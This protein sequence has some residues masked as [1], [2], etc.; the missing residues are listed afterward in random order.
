MV[1][2][3]IHSSG[4]AAMFWL[5][6]LVTAES[7]K[8]PPDARSS[9]N[10]RSPA[11]GNLSAVCAAPSGGR[12]GALESEFPLCPARAAEL[13]S[14]T[15]TAAD[16]APRLMAAQTMQKTTNPIAHASVWVRRLKF[17]S[18]NIG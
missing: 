10:I 16:L 5:K 13:D 14:A 1:R 17:G 3:R 18:I 11:V 15:T 7:S 12:V 4:I 9:Q 2:G 8:A 6:W